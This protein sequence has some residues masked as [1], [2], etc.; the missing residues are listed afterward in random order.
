FI[1]W[2]LVMI[3][4]ITLIFL[5]ILIAIWCYFCGCRKRKNKINS[6]DSD[7]Y[8]SRHLKAQQMNRQLLKHQLENDS[9]DSQQADYPKSDVKVVANGKG[10]IPARFTK[11]NYQMTEFDAAAFN[12]GFK[13]RIKPGSASFENTGFVSDTDP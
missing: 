12:R 4:L 11:G 13:K 2:L 8:Y 10:Q 6:A 3:I 7:N 1:T 5:L 9:I